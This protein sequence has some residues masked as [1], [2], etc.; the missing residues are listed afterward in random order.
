[1]I[2]FR[3]CYLIKLLFFELVL[4]TIYT[5][6]VVAGEVSP[7]CEADK[8]K[9]QRSYDLKQVMIKAFQFTGNTIFS[10]EEL[11]KITQPYKNKFMTFKELDQLRQKLTDLYTKNGYINSGAI[12]PDQKFVQGIITYQIIEG[13][14][15][16]I[17]VLTNGRLKNSYIKKRLAFNPDAPLNIDKLYE[18]FQILHQNHLIKKIK[19]E[20]LPGLKLGQ[21]IVKAEVEE[22]KSR[23]LGIEFNNHKS[24]SVG[25]ERGQFSVS[26]KNITGWGDSFDLKLGLTQGMDDL[27]LAYTLPVSSNDTLLSFQFE[28]TDS[29]VIET[30]FDEIDIN[31]KSYT[32]TFSLRH[33][34]YRTAK[35]SFYM[36]LDTELRHSKTTLLGFPYAFSP[37][38]DSLTGE[39]DVTV[40][41]FFQEWLSRSSFQVFAIRS[42]FSRGVDAFDATIN[43]SEPDSRFFSWLLQFQW[44]RRIKTL[45]DSKLIFKTNFQ[46]SR[47]PL[48]PMEK[49]SVGGINTVRGYREN[50]LV[51]DNG[52][53]SSIELRVPFLNILFPGHKNNITKKNLQLAS[54]LDF[55][56][57]WNKSIESSSVENRH[58]SAE[59]IYSTGFGI[60]WNPIER[61]DAK[62]YFGWA[63][64][65]VDNQGSTFQDHG[66]HFS[67]SYSI[68]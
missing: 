59:S 26:H 18:K 54:F 49:F 67:I 42:R 64:K 44:A 62:I 28:K 9:S 10:D 13:K 34:F 30:A 52:L 2:N 63:L 40:V 43:P 12:I 16:G 19:L 1:M 46:L 36:G 58:T 68:F 45:Q 5:S 57:A 53:I 48:L 7:V 60:L 3:S 23:H 11:L 31:A 33:P 38:V 32:C 25:E 17:E 29:E 24:P 50:Y 37:G 51:R 20:L 15:S 55:G 6:C 65:D 56:T 35:K 39:S 8:L 61:L 41:R 4:L 47:D 27:A 22:T 66:V 21:S 14:I